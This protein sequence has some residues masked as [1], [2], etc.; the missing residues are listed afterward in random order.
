VSQQQTISMVL[1][2]VLCTAGVQEECIQHAG[3][4][5]HPQCTHTPGAAVCARHS[6]CL[7]H[8]AQGL[9]Q[10]SGMHSCILCAALAGAHNSIATTLVFFTVGWQS[11]VGLLRLQNMGGTCCASGACM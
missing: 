4:R 11:E 5:S 10:H 7:R 1:L 9:L 6:S 2:C 3:R 8:A